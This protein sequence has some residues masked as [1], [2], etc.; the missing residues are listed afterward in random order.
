MSTRLSVHHTSCCEDAGGGSWGADTAGGGAELLSEAPTQTAHHCQQEATTCVLNGRALLQSSLLK[1]RW[2][3]RIQAPADGLRPPFSLCGSAGS[4]ELSCLRP[5]LAASQLLLCICPSA[6][7]LIVPG[8]AARWQV[9]AA[10]LSSLRQRS[11]PREGVSRRDGDRP[12]GQGPGLGGWGTWEAPALRSAP[13]TLQTGRPSRHLRQEAAS[14]TTGLCVAEALCAPR[15]GGPPW[16]RGQM[17]LGA[18]HWA[19]LW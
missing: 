12:G 14:T 4:W 6:S 3:D 8:G 7:P 11:C 18:N 15:G 10:L 2:A 9:T 16:P 1:R 19:L 13:R 5:G 17:P